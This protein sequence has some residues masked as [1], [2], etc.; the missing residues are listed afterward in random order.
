[1]AHRVEK[2]TMYDPYEKHLQGGWS[3]VLPMQVK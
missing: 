1:L 3:R 2:L